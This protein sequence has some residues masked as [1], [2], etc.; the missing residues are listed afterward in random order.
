LCITI[1][2]TKA[3]L[4]YRHGPGGVPFTITFP[5]LLPP[6]PFCD[7][8]FTIP[9][10]QWVHVE[11]NLSDDGVVAVSSGGSSMICASG[12]AISSGATTFQIGAEN[13]V[14]GH[15]GDVYLDNFTAVVRR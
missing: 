6:R 3:C 10:N 1:G 13:I 7:V 15:W 5:S 12:V 11:M 14:P 4:S 8:N 9:F 2:S